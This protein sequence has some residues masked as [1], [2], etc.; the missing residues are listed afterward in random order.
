MQAPVIPFFMNIMVAEPVWWSFAAVG[1]S[2]LLAGTVFWL[3]VLNRRVVAR[4]RAARAYI[5]H[6]ERLQAQLRRLAAAM[7]QTTDA[8][9]ITDAAGRIEYINRGYEQMSGFTRDEVIGRA[10]SILKSGLHDAGFYEKLWETLLAGEPFRGVFINRR[11]DGS[12]Y[13]EEKTI[14]PVR[15][16][17]D[18]VVAFVSTG[19]DISE[20]R[21]SEE[22]A[23]QQEARLA[24]IERLSTIGELSTALAHELNQPLAAI[25]NYANGSLRRLAAGDLVPEQLRTPLEE[26]ARL[27]HRAGQTIGRMRE[28]GRDRHA[29]RQSTDLNQVVRDATELASPAARHAQVAL[30]FELAE[31]LPSVVVDDLQLQQVV[32]NLV[33]N[34]IEAVEHADCVQREVTVAS[35]LAE[36]GWVEVAV[37]DTG[38]GLGETEI[39]RLLDRFFVARD[40]NEGLGIGLA[41][42]RTIVEDHGGYL[43]V[44]NVAGGGAV[45]SFVLPA[46]DRR[47]V[48]RSQPSPEAG[49]PRA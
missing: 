9:L 23:R 43:R 38:P 32:L 36:D 20:R 10:P 25:A 31:E 24:R 30:R 17:T 41:I 47:G 40:G 39:E 16:E 29:R 3:L 22:L 33:R 35:R 8:V 26:I 42:S 49:E 19:K 14:A 12:L 6:Q 11:K 5:E 4:E 48:P 46:A 18:T 45:F 37:S 27:A 7:D 1:L 34:A 28:F 21:R 15:D 44:E 2:I 13:Y